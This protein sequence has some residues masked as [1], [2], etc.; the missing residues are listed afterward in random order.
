MMY[1]VDFRVKICVEGFNLVCAFASK[2]SDFQVLH[3]RM[4]KTK[5]AVT[6]FPP[7]KICL[8]IM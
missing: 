6:W 1:Y 4:T 3:P 7:C 2:Y 5:T 8:K